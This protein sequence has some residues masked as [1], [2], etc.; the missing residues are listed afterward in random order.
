MKKLKYLIKY[1]LKKRL[2]TKAFYIS[3]A[4]IGLLIVAIT[5]LPTII[6][7]FTG[8]PTAEKVEDK[9]TVVNT[10]GY[11]GFNDLIEDNVKS[12]LAI[13]GYED[14]TQFIFTSDVLEIPNND[15]YTSEYDESARVYIYL[16]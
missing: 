16:D 10:T 5:L 12:Q 2:F 11:L 13:L 15:Y 6:N 3:T 7:V 8:E 1:G 4:V 14:D 9:I